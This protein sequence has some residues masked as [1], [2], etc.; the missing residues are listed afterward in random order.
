MI[1]YENTEGGCIPT[2]S[3]NFSA[4][5]FRGNINPFWLP[6]TFLIQL[7]HHHKTLA[8]K[9]KRK[10]KLRINLVEAFSVLSEIKMTYTK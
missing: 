7:P 9:F 4:L 2:Q 10:H 8:A 1:S 5:M 6:A 3:G